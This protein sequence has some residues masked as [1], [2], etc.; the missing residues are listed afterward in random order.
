MDQLLGHR[1]PK[2]SATDKRCAYRYRASSRLY[3]IGKRR[4]WSQF[5]MRMG[6]QSGLSANRLGDF[7]Q[8]LVKLQRLDDIRQS[9]FKARYGF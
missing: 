3:L 2:G 6:G 8:G 4:F 1:Q 9:F 7:N 5:L